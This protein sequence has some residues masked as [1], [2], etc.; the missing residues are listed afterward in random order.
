MGIE[1]KIIK[2]DE[3][4]NF[5]IVTIHL[6]PL[7]HIHPAPSTFL[8]LSPSECMI[9]SISYMHWRILAHKTALYLGPWFMSSIIKSTGTYLAL[10]IYIW[11]IGKLKNSPKTE[12]K[13]VATNWLHLLGKEIQSARQES[14]NAAL[15]RKVWGWNFAYIWISQPWL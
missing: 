14:S 2:K 1:E 6:C 12:A 7:N 5:V 11:T 10:Q 15:C 13:I 9:F 8:L 3:N 4:N